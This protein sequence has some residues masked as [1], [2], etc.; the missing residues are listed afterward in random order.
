MELEEH[1]LYWYEGCIETGKNCCDVHV[2]VYTGVV[3]KKVDEVVS[4]LVKHCVIVASLQETTQ[5]I[6]KCI[7]YILRKGRVHY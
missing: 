4:E 7:V 6:Q 1:K 5:T 2:L 3:D